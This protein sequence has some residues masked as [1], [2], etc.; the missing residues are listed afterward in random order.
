MDYSLGWLFDEDASGVAEQ[1]D[2]AFL[3]GEDVVG[4]LGGAG[5]VEVLKRFLKLLTGDRIAGGRS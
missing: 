5:V 2:Q 3:F 4:V 1:L